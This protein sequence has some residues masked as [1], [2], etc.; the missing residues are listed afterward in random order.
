[1]MY[2]LKIRFQLEYLKAINLLSN[3]EEADFIFKVAFRKHIND[4]K[5]L[6]EKLMND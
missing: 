3:I 4:R 2:F 1:M 6:K 5:K